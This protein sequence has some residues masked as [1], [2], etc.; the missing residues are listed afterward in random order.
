MFLG[1]AF[2]VAV[3]GA[4]SSVARLAGRDEVGDVVAAACV[5]LEQ[6]IGFGCWSFLAPVANG[7]LAE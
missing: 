6:V 5:M 4:A 2:R 3:P 1:G 7:F